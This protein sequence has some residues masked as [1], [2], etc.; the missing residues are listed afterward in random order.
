MALAA[1]DQNVPDFAREAASSAVQMGGKAVSSTVRAGG[2]AAGT[3]VQAGGGALGSAISAIP[4]VG[5]LGSVLSVGSNA[6]GSMISMGSGF[7]ADAIDFVTPIAAGLAG[8]GASQVAQAGGRM[9]HAGVDTLN[10]NIP[11]LGEIGGELGVNVAG[12]NAAAAMPGRMVAQ[13][14]Q[15]ASRQS[16]GGNT[17]NFYGI[18]QDM[19]AKYNE[20]ALA[21]RMGLNQVMV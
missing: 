15:S 13:A 20:M 4:V 3:A 10:A 8:E 6:A 19:K 9:M 14:S 2:Q 11:T 12:L 16:G 7:A 17:Y 18:A 5:A 21:D 1:Y